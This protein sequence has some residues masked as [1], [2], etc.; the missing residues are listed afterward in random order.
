VKIL[1]RAGTIAFFCLAAVSAAFG[2]TQSLTFMPVLYPSG[3]NFGNLTPSCVIAA[4]VNGDGKPDLICANGVG[5][6]P[7]LTI[8][9]N[10]GRGD[11]GSNAVIDVGSGAPWVVAT[12]VNGDG[13][14]DLIYPNGTTPGT[15]TVMTN[16]G[17]GI[18]GYNA[19]LAVGYGPMRVV[20]ADINGDGKVDLISMDLYGESLTVLT[21]NGSGDFGSNATIN[22]GT[23]PGS[24]IAADLNGDGKV[25]LICGSAYS[26]TLTVFTNNGR[27][28]FG[29]NATYVVGNWPNSVAAADINGDGK[30]DLITANYNA[31][32]G[33]TLTV[34]TNNGSGVFGSNATL[35]VGNGPT[36]VIAVDIN[37]DGKSDLICANQ[38]DV[39]LTVL[40]NNGSGDFGSNT[41]LEVNSY[42]V[43]VVA[44]DI[45]GDGKLDLISGDH[46]FGLTV[47]TQIGFT[48]WKYATTNDAL[49]I[50]V[51]DVNNDGKP[52]L[53]TA[54]GNYVVH[55][56]DAG[57]GDTLTVLTN[58]GSGLFGFYTNL[59]VGSE[60]DCV[61]AADVNRDGKLDLI[62]ANANGSGFGSLS[63]L[64]NNGLGGFGLDELVN[65]GEYGD[66]TCVT[67]VDVNSNG[68]IGL[69]ALVNGELQLF[70][71]N[72]NGVI[73]FN[74]VV[75]VGNDPLWVVAA[76]VNGD[77]R[78]DLILANGVNTKP[79]DPN[80][81]LTVF[82]NN[83]SGGFV[84]NATYEVGS[85]PK[86]FV[87]AD[88]NG[89]GKVDLIAAN[90]TVGTVTVLTNN[91]SGGFISNA[92]YEVGFQPRCVVAADI[93]GDGW[94]DLIVATANVD[95]TAGNTVTILTNNGSGFFGFY[96]TIAV[97]VA[98]NW[99][100]A[101][102]VNGDGKP[103]LIVTSTDGRLAVL[104]NTI[105]FSTPTTP[106]VLSTTL[107]GP[108]LVISWSSSATDLVVQTNSDLSSPNWGTAS[109]IITTNETGE[110]ITIPKPPGDLF[111][112]L[113]RP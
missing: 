108:N 4:D 42:P 60:P 22:V 41:T 75:A 50:A 58:A 110:S 24:L 90:N 85:A 54:N 38:T 102:D 8:L 43:S 2:Q 111:F 48:T 61:I 15:L 78:A 82:T 101:A 44:S 12:D 83:G 45:N 26:D 39:T 86:C 36:C 72:G 21:N 55:N 63:I 9:T 52:D 56:S 80:G 103:D 77:G 1:A 46:E 92:T 34:L 37:G 31:S 113:F 99:V 100:A 104:I 35:V 68:K 10:D 3:T 14:P 95:E 11:F 29:S 13:W 89:D 25:D 40:T 94:P 64:T 91:G 87:A 27:G 93:N 30:L 51:M 33:D 7:A 23:F 88:I 70:T 49:S 73:A 107:S 69:A 96:A 65:V 32:S 109:Y 84:S 17:H 74:A 59:A 5:T 6:T 20:A 57:A 67:A 79:D 18:F 47:Q 19:T 66:P 76:D 98:P 97:D 16:N 105:A 62:S 112:R 106:P 81:T 28:D 53:I 71:N